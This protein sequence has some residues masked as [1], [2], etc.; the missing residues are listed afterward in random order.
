VPGRRQF[1][2]DQGR[3]R[4]W[5]GTAHDNCVWKWGA[6]RAMAD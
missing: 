6:T 4:A 2:R 5:A 1:V 3:H